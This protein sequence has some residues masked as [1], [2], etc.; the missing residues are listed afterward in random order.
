MKKGQGG[1][2]LLKLFEKLF[3][4]LQIGLVTPGKGLLLTKFSRILCDCENVA[5]NQKQRDLKLFDW[6][7]Y[8]TGAGHILCCAV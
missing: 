5:S 6:L 8:F 2:F 7:P 1:D 3:S 4:F